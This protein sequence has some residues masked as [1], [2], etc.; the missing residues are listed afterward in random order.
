MPVADSIQSSLRRGIAYADELQPRPKDRDPW[1]WSHCVRFYTRN[2]LAMA[3]PQ[4]KV[5]G[6]EV[7]QGVPNF[8]IHMRRDLHLARL[9]R[10]LGGTTP[11]PGPNKRRREAW[12]GVGRGV[13]QRLPLE[14][15]PLATDESGGPVPPLSF[16]LDWTTDDE[17]EPVVHVG[18]PVE[19]WTFHSRKNPNL[20]WRRP[21]PKSEE[22]LAE[23]GFDEGAND[24]NRSLITVDL[25]PE[26]FGID[27]R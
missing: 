6:W 2:S 5:N 20:Y 10:S 13:P 25:A 7:L 21:L 9:V 19:D 4:P 24:D 15:L 16:I 8:G 17:G 26:E 12:I 1:F 23:L 18:L 3:H 22:D 27:G 14:K 11:P